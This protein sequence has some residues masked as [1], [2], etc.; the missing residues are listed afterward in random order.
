MATADSQQSAAPPR[1]T[2][3]LWRLTRIYWTSPEAPRGAALLGLAIA[4]E[5]ATVRANV[6]VAQTQAAVGDGLQ[7]LDRGAFFTGLGWFAFAA[8]AVIFASAFRIYVRQILEIT[9]R[10]AVT[11]DFLRRWVGVQSYWQVE[12]HTGVIDNPDQRIAEDV[13]DYVASALG[14]SL[15]LLAAVTTLLSFGVMLWVVSSD[16]P[17]PIAD[18]DVWI[19]G[20]MVWVAV[21]S[22]VA[23]TL[24]THLLGRRLVP[25]NNDRLRVEADFRYGLVRYR[26]TVESV[27]LLHGNRRERV[28]LL[29]R[30]GAVIAN[31]WQLIA[32][33]RDLSLLT[34]G[35]GQVNTLLPLLVAAPA[36]FGGHLTL[37]GLVQVRFAYGQVAGGL[38]WFVNAYQE[39]A[40]WRANIER[41]A[42][43]A[44][45]MD[46]TVDDVG[47]RRG[48]SR[49]EAP[50]GALQLDQLQLE[51][52][53]GR[54]LLAPVSAAAPAG[55]CTAI[56]GPPGSGR[57]MLVRAL[58][59][60]WPFGAGRVALPPRQEV[61]VIP[62][63][64]YLPIG[65]L[66]EVLYYPD[67][68]NGDA[69]ACADALRAVGLEALVA[70]LD[71]S[72]HWEQ[73][74]SD[75]ERQ[76][77]ALARA[78]VRRPAWLVLDEATS[79]LDEA[80]ERALF[81]LLR[82]R[83][84]TTGVLAVTALPCPF[85]ADQRWLL[86]PRPGTGSLLHCEPRATTR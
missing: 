80:N 2:R 31:W 85:G 73:R 23:A 19:P 3:D 48:V 86:E 38:T 24:F 16:W 70:Q 4:L 9:W 5:L 17:L 74:V 10:R 78:L 20:L 52:P 22:S 1:F 82:E 8:L 72:A 55:A 83:L 41:L 13:R 47:A 50:A 71:T 11:D 53:D 44:D 21:A 56:S 37:G 58:A 84:P 7:R 77:L 12:L 27:A 65:T 14:L 36:F 45:L 18:H 57:T 62:Q 59:D 29:D 63:R 25:I 81:A 40:R 68:P 49:A 66:R 30:F 34:Q 35:I 79:S 51:T 69:A 33:Q 6:W 43:F 15:S 54:P 42:R 76:R 75:G 32:A 61:D 60:V 26:D 64:A 67:A 46:R 28:R 39:I